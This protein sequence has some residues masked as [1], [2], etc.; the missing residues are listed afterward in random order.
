MKI[1]DNPAEAAHVIKGM[2]A[3]IRKKN[4]IARNIGGRFWTYQS[5]I[6]RAFEKIDAFAK[7]LQGYMEKQ[8]G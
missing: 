5:P 8:G 6:G 2:M 1:I 4:A 3:S 7:E